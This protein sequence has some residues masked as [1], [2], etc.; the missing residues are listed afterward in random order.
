MNRFHKGPPFLELMKVSALPM[1]MS[2]LLVRERSTYF[3]IE[4][5]YL[6]FDG[7]K[8]GEATEL[9][10]IDGFR[11]PIRISALSAYH[12][13]FHPEADKI[14]SDLIQNGRV[15]LSLRGIHYEEYDG[16]AFR[17][18]DE[19]KWLIYQIKSKIMIDPAGFYGSNPKY[20]W[21][22]VNEKRAS[23]GSHHMDKK[24]QIKYVDIDPEQLGDDELT[25]FNP[26]VPG[27][28]LGEKRFCLLLSA[29]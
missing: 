23:F 9:I 20:L 17:F 18:D 26:T 15:F 27:F 16:Q 4:G 21:K 2:P 29:C 10:R 6:D 5:R 3:Q 11:G 24:W 28:S 19:G 12:L 25:L 14:R 22:Q 8:I 13:Q 1:R 7:T